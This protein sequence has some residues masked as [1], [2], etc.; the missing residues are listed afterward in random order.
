MKKYS[1]EEI[2]RKRKLWWHIWTFETWARLAE[3]VGF[4]LLGLSFLGGERLS[5]MYSPLII[6]GIS[7]ILMCFIMMV[8]TKFNE[9]NNF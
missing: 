2:A 5:A 4:I 3:V 7:V 1:I 8:I 6:Y 9:N